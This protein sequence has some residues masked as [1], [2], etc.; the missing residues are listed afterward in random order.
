MLLE[1]ERTNQLRF[2]LMTKKTGL[3]KGPIS[4]EIL[5]I[6]Q[7]G[8][9]IQTY[10]TSPIVKVCNMQGRAKAKNLDEGRSYIVSIVLRASGLI[11]VYSDFELCNSFNLAFNS[12]RLFCV[13]L[14]ADDE[15]VYFR[16]L[17][18]QKSK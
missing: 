16:F 10:G 9:E 12:K 2:V 1:H 8:P 18:L 13:D 15:S 3:Q 14:Q 7:R 6:V 5:G 4:Y 17:N 11:E